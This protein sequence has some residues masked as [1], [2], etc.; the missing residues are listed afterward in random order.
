M[1]PEKMDQILDIGIALTAEKD[2]HALLEKIMDGA[3]KIA[4]CDGGTLYLKDGDVLRFTIMRNRS[5]GTYQGGHGEAI[6]L[7]PVPIDRDH[8]SSLALLEDRTI[9]IDDAYDPMLAGALRGPRAY[10]ANLGYHT[11][12][13]LVVPMKNPAGDQIGVLQLIN[14]LDADGVPRPFDDDSMRAVQSIASQAAVAIQNVRYLQEIRKLFESYVETSIQAMGKLTPFNENHTRN[15]VCYCKSFLDYLNTKAVEAGEPIPYPKQRYEELVMSTWLHDLGK[16]VT[17]VDIMNKNARLWPRQK[18][19]IQHRMEVLL[20]QMEVMVLKGQAS[21]EEQ[22]LV[23]KRAAELLAFVERADCAIVED[24]AEKLEEL[25]SWTYVDADGVKRP[26]L[27]DDEVHQLSV[28]YRTLTDEEFQ[29][30]H[31]HVVHTD[32]LL[33]KMKFP[34]D[35]AHVRQWAPMHHELLNG[36]GYPNNLAGDEIPEEVRILTIL[37]IFEALTAVDREYKQPKTPAEAV[38]HLHRIAGFGEVDDE[39]V[40]LFEESQCWER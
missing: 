29:I 2:I 23:E 21:R 3:M 11:E 30:M 38:A 25:A 34:A 22:S 28:P 16:L 20:L 35:M 17:P 40:T 6:D 31:D 14:A 27:L 37:D 26:Y 32:E 7:P 39:L 18:A 5:L 36:K 15:M 4:E 1:T 12:S 10:D 19:N 8:I 9:R 13:V 33:A 24:R